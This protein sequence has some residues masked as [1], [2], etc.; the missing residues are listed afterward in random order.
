MALLPNNEYNLLIKI[1]GKEFRFNFWSIL[2]PFYSSIN[3]IRYSIIGESIIDLPDKE[4]TMH[5]YDNSVLAEEIA[6]HS[7]NPFDIES[8]PFYVRKYVEEKTKYD[9][10]F[11]VYLSLLNKSSKSTQLADFSIQTNA[12]GD[13]KDLLDLLK[14]SYLEWEEM[15]RGLNNRGRAKPVYV[16]KGGNNEYPL[17]ER[18]F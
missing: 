7:N 14:R 12:P 5:I 1:K 13:L 15:I 18:G 8:P 10:L 2:S 11:M 16:V 4:I 17:S 6:N 3:I 9:L